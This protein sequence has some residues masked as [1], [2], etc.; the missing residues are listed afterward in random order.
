MQEWASREHDSN[1]EDDC[2]KRNDNKSLNLDESVAYQL[3]AATRARNPNRVRSEQN[4]AK[5]NRL[6]AMWTSTHAHGARDT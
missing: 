6:T 1:A 5:R 3:R 4:R 2:K